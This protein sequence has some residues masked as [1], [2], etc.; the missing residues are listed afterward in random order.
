MIK[1]IMP[2][3]NMLKVTSS[4]TGWRVGG[5]SKPS[6]EELRAPSDSIAVPECDRDRASEWP[7]A[8]TSMLAMLHLP[9]SK[10]TPSDR[11]IKSPSSRSLYI[12]G[13]NSAL[14][15]T[16]EFHMVF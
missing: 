4:R 7:Q 6:S 9:R 1:A 3:T 13:R 15:T 2:D 14:L 11:A 10:L 5:K 8:P 16:A 12:Q